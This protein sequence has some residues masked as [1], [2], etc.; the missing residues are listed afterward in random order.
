[1]VARL[2]GSALLLAVVAPQPVQ[3]ASAWRGTEWEIRCLLLPEHVGADFISIDDIQADAC[4]F[5]V[6]ATGAPHSIGLEER[7]AVAADLASAS[8]LLASAGYPEPAVPRRG[9]RWVTRLFPGDCW[10]SVQNCCPRLRDPDT[11]GTFYRN[12]TGGVIPKGGE[13]FV[14]ALGRPRDDERSVTAAHE[15]FH[16]VTW[17]F[18][19]VRELAGEGNPNCLPSC[20]IGEGGA[21]AFGYFWARRAGRASDAGWERTY[22]ESLHTGDYGQGTL[23]GEFWEYVAE[24]QGSFTALRHVY[25]QP[26]DENPGVG[27]AV[28]QAHRGL[29]ASGYPAGLHG[30]YLDFAGTLLEDR[31][32]ERVPR[33]RVVREEEDH[34]LELGAV[35]PIAVKAGRVSLARGVVDLEH[36]AEARVRLSISIADPSSDDLHLLVEGTR[37]ESG[38]YLEDV[39]ETVRGGGSIERFVQV[40]NVRSEPHESTLRE[41]V[42]VVARVEVVE[43]PYFDLTVSGPLF[44]SAQTFRIDPKR[45]AFNVAGAG[46]FVTRF[47]DRFART[48]VSA[49]GSVLEYFVGGLHDRAFNAPGRYPLGPIAGGND[50]WSLRIWA[51]AAGCPERF[52]GCVGIGMLTRVGEIEV[53]RFALGKGLSRPHLT[54]PTLVEGRFEVAASGNKPAEGT[55]YHLSGRF[56]LQE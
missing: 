29:R 44:A 43:C 41:G 36:R 37:Q 24:R 2:L 23:T 11:Q 34:R 6:R 32:Y 4:D 33:V 53:T 25:A 13:L 21:E 28:L 27:E 42:A 15:L 12:I 46:G 49:D 22:D 1:M 26:F 56:C 16:A 39:T 55:P 7:A 31:F 5:R 50:G 19:G 17:S 30:A 35:E 45:M 54:G 8:A 52:Q 40:A 38:R 10:C 3:G 18:P 48:A 20:W 51:Q 9:D 14:K 47:Q